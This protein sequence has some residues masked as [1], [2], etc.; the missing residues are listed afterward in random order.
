MKE[1]TGSFDLQSLDR[2]LF[3][4]LLEEEALVES[5]ADPLMNGRIRSNGLSRAP[6]SFSQARLW[7]FEQLEPSGAAY[8][9]PGG[10]RLDGGLQIDALAAA[11]LEITRRQESLRTSFESTGGEGEQ[12]IQPVEALYR[13]RARYVPGLVDISGLPEPARAGV[14]EALATDEARRPFDLSAA[15]L[16]RTVLIRCDAGNHVLLTTMHHVVSDEWSLSVFVCELPV[17][18]TWFWSGLPSDLE[19][20][21]I[22]YS[23]YTIWQRDWLQG[24]VLDRQIEYWKAQLDQLPA[25]VELPAD[26]PRPAV[27]SYRG[28]L[29]RRELRNDLSEVLRE[30]ARGQGITLFMLLLAVYEVFI[31]RHTS[32][33]DFVIG[34]PVAGRDQLEVQNLIG[35]FVNMLALRAALTADVPVPVLLHRVRESA[36]GAYANQSLPF[37]LLVEAL[38]PERDLAGPALF[39]VTFSLERRL[40]T[41][42]ELPNLTASPVESHT[43]TSKFDLI[44]SFADSEQGLTAS[45]EYRRDLFDA[46]TIER[47]LGHLE[48]LLGALAA[49]F[50]GGI[51]SLPLLS[52]AETNQLLEEWNDTSAGYPA[53]RCI[54]QMF[55]EQAALKP[56]RVAVVFEDE[57]L[58]Y[59]ELNRRANRLAHY[60]R[61]RGVGVE[62]CVG[63]CVE[64]SLA[65]A[66]ALLGIMKA[67]GAYLPLDPD[68][69]TE[70][71]A[72]MISDSGAALIV[73]GKNQIDRVPS[74]KA[75]ILNLDKT[76]R[77]VFDVAIDTDRNP[78]SGA[79]PANLI[80]LIYTSGSTGN[81]K[82]TAIPH[83]GPL[84]CIS[85]LQDKFRF[86]GRDRLLMKASLSFDAS[87]WE[88]FWPLAVGSTVVM[89]VPGGEQDSAYL[90]AAISRLQATSCQF[91]PSMLRVFIDEAGF[92]DMGG[93]DLAFSLGE[94]LP[95]ETMEGFLRRSRAD[96]HNF[97]G[98]T[99]TSMGCMDWLCLRDWDRTSVPIGRPISNIREYVFDGQFSPVP[100]GVAG[101]LYISGEGVAFG[102]HGRPDLTAE[103]FLP[104]PNGDCVG[105]RMYRSG[106]L[107][108]YLP[109]GDIEFL[110]RIDQQVKVRGFRIE[111][112]EIEA[113]LARHESVRECL[114]VAHEYTTAD[115]RL[116]AY[117]VPV[118]GAE[119]S[120]TELRSFVKERLPGFMSP[121][122]FVQLEKLPLTANGKVNRAALP[123]PEAAAISAQGLCPAP[124]GVQVD[125]VEELV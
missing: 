90:L 16:V 25:T 41:A 98:P 37:E 69:P 9:M 50:D 70:R 34:T 108:R 30:A 18:Y 101:E 102:Y 62:T 93:F 49:G 40:P 24:E 5:A 48:V 22:Q 105:S 2:D 68:Y 67:G 46:G 119:V 71:L 112:G 38:Q 27:L 20:P 80:Y 66:I 85:W 77:E 6:L 125:A 109:N 86:G 118:N 79:T 124:G 76:I 104:D 3:E 87:V 72:Y 1:S 21:G 97:Y 106:D 55:E 42:I 89:I 14:T 58:T 51:G 115:Q 123:I 53:D 43:G 15:P 82:G 10:L 117:V 28:G 103:K 63:L 44:L 84:N 121:A 107:C 78:E 35:F 57:Q 7:F 12:V 17:L 13:D 94:A 31:F 36:L 4:L 64:R 65:M 19:E 45:F 99:E 88:I 8:N 83:R 56:D 100:I 29:V 81:P 113:A 26:Y 95:V 92:A 91:V 116:I 61:G 11:L 52:E 54:H 32:Q 59:F 120:A 39:N 114:V 23:D 60:L 111:L 47:M 33:E 110:G 74:T 73:A 75:G 122:Y 96:L